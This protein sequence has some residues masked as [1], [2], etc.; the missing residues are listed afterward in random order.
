MRSLLTGTLAGRMTGKMSGIVLVA[1]LAAPFGAF[2]QRMPDLSGIWSRTAQASGSGI[3]PNDAN[4][5][6]FL[7]FSKDIPPFTAEGLEKY[8]A[9][10]RGIS[11]ARARGRDDQDPLAFC[12]PPGPT[13]IFTEPKTFEIRQVPEMAYI[14]SEI[15]HI[16]RRIQIGGEKVEGYPPT[17]HGYSVGRYDG[18]T[19]VVDT[20]EFNEQTWL[21]SLGTVHSDALKLAERFR[22]TNRDTLEIAV[23]FD[24]PKT[25]TK[26]WGGKK[27]Y[28]LLP[29]AFEMPDNAICEEF[30]KEGLRKSGFEFFRE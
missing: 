2:A 22:R 3:Y 14:I 12:Y 13:R 10:R 27:L 15:D 7:G 8:K 19:L 6:P 28:Q 30:R 11:D 24:D 23:T 9:N 5:A 16:V 21:D 4:G 20:T 1:M 29:A 25:F 26:P 17:W 18:E